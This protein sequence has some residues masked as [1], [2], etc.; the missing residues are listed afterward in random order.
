[1][2]GLWVKRKASS[3]FLLTASCGRFFSTTVDCGDMRSGSE[4]IMRKEGNSSTR[5]FWGDVPV[6]AQGTSTNCEPKL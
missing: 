1:M 2:V 4:G 6:G 3:L 5:R